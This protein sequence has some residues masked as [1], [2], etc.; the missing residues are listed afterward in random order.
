[1]PTPPLTPPLTPDLVTLLARRQGMAM[2]PDRAKVIA[3]ILAWPLD[4]AGKAAAGLPFEAEPSL[5]ARAFAL[6]CAKRP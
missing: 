2:A 5:L 6:A 4:Q 1:M 3:D